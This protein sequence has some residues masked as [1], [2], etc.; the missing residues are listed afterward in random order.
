MCELLYIYSF[1]LKDGLLLLKERNFTQTAKQHTQIEFKSY[2]F[3]FLK[4]C[5]YC[6]PNHKSISSK[7]GKKIFKNCL[8]IFKFFKIERNF[9]F[10]PNIQVSNSYTDLFPKKIKIKRKRLWVPRS[11]DLAKYL[12]QF[13]LISQSTHWL[14]GIYL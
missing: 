1:H 3:Y 11:K 8:L 6:K 10:W 4:T 5:I 13:F 7:C 14:K 2:F 12:K 9:F